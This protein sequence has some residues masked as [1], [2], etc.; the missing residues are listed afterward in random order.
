MRNKKRIAAMILSLAMIFPVLSACSSES[1]SSGGA[2]QGTGGTQDGYYYTADEDIAGQID[3]DDITDLDLTGL[4]ESETDL[5]SK[6]IY[7]AY[8]EVET[9]DFDSS[10]EGIYALADRFGAFLESSSVTGANLNSIANGYNYNRSANFVLRVP[11]EN[12]GSISDALSTVGNIT[13]LESYAENITASY[14]DAQSRLEAYDI[15]EER[16]LAIMEQA[17]TVDDLIALETRLSEVRYQKESLTSQISNWDNQV[18]YST[19]T[20][21]LSE[22]TVL[23][24]TPDRTYWQTIRDGFLETLYDVGNGAKNVFRFILVAS[25]VLVIIAAVVV[26]VC[27][28]IRHHRRKKRKAAGEGKKVSRRARKQRE[29][30]GNSPETK[31]DSSE[32]VPADDSPSEKP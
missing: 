17:E 15:E 8:A 29:A 12:F 10:V 28:L 23:T 6:I 13:Y 26:I 3:W 27:L 32:D 18:N 22:V 4:M 7:S 30:S 20:V 21:K 11:K 16:L 9:T 19:V 14:T 31:T 2:A 24:P 1:T 5:A 25:P